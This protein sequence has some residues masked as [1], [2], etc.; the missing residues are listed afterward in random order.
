MRGVERMRC[1]IRQGDRPSVGLVHV[2]RLLRRRVPIPAIP[3][4]EAL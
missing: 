1:D 4:L 3:C 2:V